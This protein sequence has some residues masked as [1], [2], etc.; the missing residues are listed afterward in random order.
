MPRRQAVDL[1]YVQCTKLCD[2]IIACSAKIWEAVMG[3]IRLVLLGAATFAVALYLALAG[4]LYSSQDRLLYVG[5]AI[6]A[7]THLPPGPFIPDG[8]GHVW[9]LVANPS[10][11]AKATVLF[12]HGNGNQA[13]MTEAHDADFFTSRGYRVVFAEYP[14]YAGRAGSPSRQLVTADAAALFA[15]VRRRYHDTPLWLAGESLGAGIAALTARQDKPA[16]VLLF[17]P[18][19][20]LGA[21]AA[22]HYPYMPVQLLLRA[23][24]DS[25]AGLAGMGDRTVIVYADRDVVIPPVRAR[26]LAQCLAVPDSQVIELSQ[27]G[28][29][30]WTTNLTSAQ[31]NFLLP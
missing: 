14:G 21:V 3:T 11:T 8:Q 20:R 1:N 26:H 10:G 29:G 25:C 30:D 13:W 6:P 2:V 9:A 18:W 16:R 15:E 22:E 27:S 7:P 5:T 23:D 4:I 12:F 17:V 31:W 24:Y 28:H 19:D